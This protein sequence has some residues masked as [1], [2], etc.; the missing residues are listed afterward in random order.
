MS[1]ATQVKDHLPTVPT[2]FGESKLVKDIEAKKIKPSIFIGSSSESYFLAETI[3]SKF[4][5]D[6]EVDTWKMSVFNKTDKEGRELTIA[7]QLKNFTDIYD[8][9]I[10]LF[11]PDEKVIAQTRIIEGTTK[12]ANA[13]ATKHN[14]IFEFGLFLGRLGAKN[15]VILYHEDVQDFIDLFFTDLKDT[16]GKEESDLASHFKIIIETFNGNYA[17]YLKDGNKERLLAELDQI[18]EYKVK[19]IEQR[20]KETFSEVSFGFLPSTSQAHG[21]YTNFI[22]RMVKTFKSL[23]FDIDNTDIFVRPEEIT[24]K[25]LSKKLVIFYIIEPDNLIETRYEAFEKYVKEGGKLKSVNF[26]SKLG[27]P[28]TVYIKSDYDETSD[29]ME[30]YDFPTVLGASI[31]AI[32]F[33]T[34]D[35]DIR[36]LLSEKE[37]RNFRK[38]MKALLKERGNKVVKEGFEFRI[39]FLGMREFEMRIS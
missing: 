3:K 18:L 35:S 12:T 4:S 16:V 32:E 10:F 26:K 30:I 13:M 1:K 19:S 22:E 29:I 36:E 17:Q 24:D 21:Y 38:V 39:E 6:F 2:E 5:T 8:F 7:E 20:F 15:S 11:V 14:V 25:L 23:L 28:C 27:R 33:A 34:Q 37:K 31:D 9:A